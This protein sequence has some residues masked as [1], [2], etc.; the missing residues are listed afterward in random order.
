VILVDLESLVDP[1]LLVGLVDPVLLV[2]LVG[3][4]DPVL[5]QGVKHKMQD[6]LEL[7]V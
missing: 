5:Q 7:C 2:G 1:V 6:M 3:L 4:E